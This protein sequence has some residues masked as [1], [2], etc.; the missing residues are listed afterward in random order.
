MTTTHTLAA[1]PRRMRP[2][3]A[4]LLVALATAAA[5]IVGTSS[6]QHGARDDQL[7]LSFG[8]GP[9][10]NGKAVIAAG[11]ALEVPEHGIVA[12]LS[13]AMQET[14]MLN[15]ANPH[16]PDSLALAHDGLG[17]DH[18]AVGVLQQSAAWGPAGE[19]MSPAAAATKF[20]TAMRAVPDW[21]ALPAGEL[22]GLVQRAAWP[23]TYLDEVPAARQFYRD[24]L[25]EIHTA[26]CLDASVN[27]EGLAEA[28]P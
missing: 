16:V 28:H 6:L 8:S 27:A 23:Q 22:A 4:V 17:A 11:V 1:A 18:D 10:N 25:G 20:F 2:L 15:L 21:E 19:R 3:L 26:H 12:G 5:L 9:V 24:H 14:R 7:C 13:A